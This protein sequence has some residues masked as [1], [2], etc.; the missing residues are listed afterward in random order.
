M[1]KAPDEDFLKNENKKY[2]GLI[3]YYKRISKS[4]KCLQILTEESALPYLLRKK[5]CTKY[6]ST[7]YISPP[8]LQIDYINNLK[9]TKPRLI[10]FSS[11]EIRF[12]PK[13]NQ[14]IKYIEKNYEFH[15]I[16]KNWTFMQIK[17][18]K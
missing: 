6:F 16:Y 17:N 15:S 12:M 4:D 8:H 13:F 3:D 7:W 10:L 9:E 1:V 2:I 18:E 14:V 5:N 11:R